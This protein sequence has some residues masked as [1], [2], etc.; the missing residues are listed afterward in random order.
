[1]NEIPLYKTISNCNLV[2]F[3]TISFMSFRGVRFIDFAQLL[4]VE[5]IF[6]AHFLS[7]IWGGI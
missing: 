3:L 7:G 6:D 2:R 1:M 5:C 4:T